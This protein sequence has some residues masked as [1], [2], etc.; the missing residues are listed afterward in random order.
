[1]NAHFFQVPH[2]HLIDML[3]KAVRYTINPEICGTLVAVNGDWATIAAPPDALGLR[4]KDDVL[5]E[6]IEIARGGEGLA[7]MWAEQEAR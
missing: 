1:M 4:R 7:E 2:A 3:G 5:C 6:Y